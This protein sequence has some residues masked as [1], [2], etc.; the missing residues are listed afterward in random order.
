MQ[1]RLLIIAIMNKFY[2]HMNIK[3]KYY[4][5]NYNLLTII[6]IYINF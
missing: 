2:R 1:K 4:L 3:V 6:N 5:V